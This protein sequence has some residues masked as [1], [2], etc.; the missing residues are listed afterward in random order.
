MDSFVKVRLVFNRRK[1]A[2]LRTAKV[3][4]KGAVEIEVSEDGRRK[5][6]STG[7]RIFLDQWKDGM[8]VNH[9]DAGDMN[10]HLRK[11]YEETISRANGNL[12]LTAVSNLQLAKLDFCDWMEEQIAERTDIEEITRKAHYRTVEC[13][14]QSGL[15]RRFSDLTERNVTL[16]DQQLKKRLNKQSAVHGYHKR[17]KTYISRAMHLGLI[18]ESPYRFVKVPK[19]KSDGIKYLTPEERDRI[20]AL[21]LSGTLGLA[22]DMFIFACYTGLA[23]CDLVRVKDCLIQDGGEWFIDGSRLKTSVKYKL[24]VLPKALEI[25]ERYDFDLNRLS[26]QKCNLNLKAVQAM[27]GIRTNLTMHVGRHTFATWALKMGVA[28]P[29]VS[30]M[31][32]HTNI[33]TTQIYAKVLQSEVEKGFDLLRQS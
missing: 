15:F 27:A 10:V 13:L 24:T 28:L 17:L 7:V 8:V 5:W 2:T 21:E 18:K 19:G 22:R 16:W 29:V 14:R 25:L 30:K 11:L 1:I 31:L 20:E 6:A 33:V 12:G 26:N 4:K 23:Y 32:A 3:P 9:I